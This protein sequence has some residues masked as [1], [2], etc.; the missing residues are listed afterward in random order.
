MSF[1]APRRAAA[2]LILLAAAG[3]VAADPAPAPAPALLVLA[4]QDFYYP[5]YAPLRA[6]LEA[7]GVPVVVA[8][9]SL[10]IALPHGNAPAQAVQPDIALADAVAADFSTIVIVGGWGAA[11]FATSFPGTF[12]QPAYRPEPATSAA[13]DALVSDFVAQ[14]KRVA[15]LCFGVAALAWTRV[16]GESPLMGRDVVG[17]AGG[18]PGFLLDGVDHAAAA[19]STRWHVESNGATMRASGSVGD[20]T[21]SV[22]DVV[23]DG[24]IVTGEDY[25]SAPELGRVLAQ[26]V[27]ADLT[28]PDAPQPQPHRALMVIANEDFWYREYAEPRAEL[29]A[30]G[31]AVDVAAA[32]DATCFPH[33]GSGYTDGSGAVDPDLTISEALDLAIADPSRWDAVIFVGGWGS[34]SYQYSFAGTY[35]T[36]SYNGSA[37]VRSDVNDLI[38]EFAAQDKWVTALCHGVSVLA[39]ARVDGVSPIA[40]RTVMA[41]P[42]MAPAEL[43]PDGTTT[44]RTT[45]AHVE[46]NGATMLPTHSAGD[47]FSATDDV[48][49]D[50]RII[51]GESFD[52]SAEFGIV[53]A[54]AILSE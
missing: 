45:R 54:N 17:Y 27:I 40:G 25:N 35:E 34:S 2:A 7:E 13:L 50:G 33:A 51:T 26:L 29:E 19:I 32:T 49:V 11:S 48:V 24:L 53:V 12:H 52:A 1:P 37:D 18:G 10:E 8:A 42:Y 44:Q 3:S 30:R 28:T 39:Y 20:P 9:P 21:T 14:E 15:A 31:I 22:D 38:G 6:A 4:Q 16:D 46:L 23:V 41:W 43:N 36:A 47:P 5:D